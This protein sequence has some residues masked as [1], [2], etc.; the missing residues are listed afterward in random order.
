MGCGGGGAGR[1]GVCRGQQWGRVAAGALLPAT[2]CPS[3]RAHPC[4]P[5]CLACPL[6][7]SV[8]TPLPEPA[9]REERKK[10]YVEKGKSEARAA[11][12]QR[13]DD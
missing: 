3:R 2:T 9:C 6:S 10:R 8:T 7:T 5:C 11:K 12:K 1:V 13:R 4:N